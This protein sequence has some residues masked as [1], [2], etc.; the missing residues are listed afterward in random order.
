MPLWQ[1]RNSLCVLWSNRDMR[2]LATLVIAGICANPSLADQMFTWTDEA[3]VV[4]F[5]QWAPNHTAG[6]TTL[7][8]ASSNAADYDPGSDPYSIQN[9]AARMNETWSKIEERRAERRKRREEA[10]ERMARLQP[11]TYY[12]PSYPYNYYRPIVRPPIHRPVHP[13]F[14]GHKRPHAGKIQGR[15]IA[16]MNE[17]NR[18]PNQRVPYSPVTGVSQRATINNMS[19]ISLPMH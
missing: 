8:T 13:I 5:S 15:Q 10:E 3:G 14:P 19:A 17:I 9:Q 18:R 12:Y 4:H 7:K 2:I 11:P 6:V 1:P 16:L